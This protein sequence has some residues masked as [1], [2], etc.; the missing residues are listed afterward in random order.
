MS[1]P[2]LGAEPGKLKQIR[3]RDVAIRFAFGAAVSILAGLV[4]I[5][6]NPVAGGLFLAFPAILPASVT[7]IEQKESTGEAAHDIEGATIGALGLAVFAVVTGT[8]LR[9]T[10]AVVALIAA[11]AAWLVSSVVLYLVIESLLRSRAQHRPTVPD[12]QEPGWDN[13]GDGGGRQESPHPPELEP[14]VAPDVARHRPDAGGVG[15]LPPV[16]DLG[17]RHRRRLSRP[18]TDQRDEEG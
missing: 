18:G 16:L 3:G 10:T 17:G 15:L 9:H 6:F 7:L 8:I 12:G 1:E 13:R 2:L 5:V 11:T 4:S 14:V